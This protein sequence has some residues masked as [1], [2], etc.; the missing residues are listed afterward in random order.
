MKRAIILCIVLILAFALI[1]CQKIESGIEVVEKEELPEQKEDELVAVGYGWSTKDNPKEAVQEA[2]SMIGKE[3]GEKSP[4]YV[5]LF[6]TVGYDSDTVLKEVK[7]LLPNT[8][9]YGGTSLSGVLT[10]DGF[11]VGNKDS[12]SLLAV[13]SQEI[14][15]GVGGANID[16]FTSAREAGKEAIKSAIKN[17]QKEGELPK[18]VLITAAPGNEEDILL[19]IEDVIG[20]DIP[21]VGGSSGD[22]DLT[23]KWKQFANDKIYSNGISLTAVFTDL[24]VGF[25][26]EIGYLT[27]KNKGIITNATGRIIYEID[28]K[29]AAEVYNEWTHGLI[30]DN[31]KS[32]GE[33]LS[34][35]NLYPLVRIMK[36]KSGEISYLSIHP[37]SVNL[38]EKSLA[39]FANVN[40]GEEVLLVDGN[41]EMLLNRAQNTPR[42]A[43][44]SQDIAKGD[45]YFGVYTF[46]A[47]TLLTIPEEE[48]HKMPLL[49]N[50]ALGGIPFIGTFT[51]GEQVFVPGVGNRH[52]NLISSM[53][54]FSR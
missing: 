48:R 41:W 16:S 4:D 33:I 44:M 28:N 7:S 45:G 34:K 6:S 18:V 40:E 43:L 53:L 39:V 17:A 14:K 20:K 54:V 11:H 38:P 27:T 22:N 23:G 12:L 1:G 21:I 15:F 26:Y 10:K 2:V 49:I 3:L 37:A 46:C 31:L 30:S 29:P 32:G 42:K 24:K 47:G 19:G 5:I 36:S 51:L 13:S 50:R 8:Q 35:T 9:I 52:G 25:A